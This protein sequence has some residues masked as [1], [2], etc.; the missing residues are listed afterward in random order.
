MSS[1]SRHLEF[2]MDNSKRFLDFAQ[3]DKKVADI[4]IAVVS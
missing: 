2:Q 1:E 3:N 4:W